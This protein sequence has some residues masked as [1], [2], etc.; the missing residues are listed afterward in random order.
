M[1]NK[2]IILAF[3]MDDTLVRTGDYLHFNLRHLLKM[4]SRPDLIAEIDE[5][6]EKGYS[7]M[8]YPLHLKELI[9]KHFVGTGQ[10]MLDAQ[11]SELCSL[12][13]IS[14]LRDLLQEFQ[15]I[16]IPLICTHRGFHEY[17]DQYTRVW[18]ERRGLS[19]LFGNVH[20]IDPQE[21]KDK[22][23]Y[24][25]SL[26]P[27]DEIVLVDDNPL[28]RHDGVHEFR[29]EILL[30]EEENPL[31]AYGEMKKIKSMNCVIEH[32]SELVY[33]LKGWEA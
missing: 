24:L 19:T 25:K 18:I 2:K 21:H 26:Y 7:T 1:T 6:R 4:E 9:D 15:G 11:P 20:C 17:G 31:T 22:I 5:L 33:Q 32:V 16:I 23:V 10:F 13:D 12:K 30:Y 29:K 8:N 3:D 27:D 28:G 14:S